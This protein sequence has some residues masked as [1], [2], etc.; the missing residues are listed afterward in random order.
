MAPTGGFGA[1][2]LFLT[3]SRLALA[4]LNHLRL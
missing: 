3:D 2:Q 1:S 4:L